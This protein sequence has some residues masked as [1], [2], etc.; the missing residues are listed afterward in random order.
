MCC[1][2]IK[3]AVLGSGEGGSGKL[4]GNENNMIKYIVYFF[5]SNE[6]TNTYS[7]ITQLYT[8]SNILFRT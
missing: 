2:I 3:Q 6:E 4:L 7:P 5:I 1:C 8:Q